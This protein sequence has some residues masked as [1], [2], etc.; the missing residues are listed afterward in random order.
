MPNRDLDPDHRIWPEYGR[1]REELGLL[2]NDGKPRKL[3]N[4]ENA[5]AIRRALIRDEPGLPKNVD[6]GRRVG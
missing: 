6:P 4:G 1:A 2:R 3:S 5:A